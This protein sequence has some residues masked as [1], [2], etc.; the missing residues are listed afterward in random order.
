MSRLF[1]FATSV[2]C[3]FPVFSI[4][5]TGIKHNTYQIRILATNTMPYFD[6]YLF[7]GTEL[8]PHWAETLRT[9]AEDELITN[10]KHS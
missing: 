6:Q 2:K 5:Q 8:K 3:F 9:D 7:Q 1:T 4:D 10:H